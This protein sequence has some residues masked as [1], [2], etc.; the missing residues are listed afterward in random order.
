MAVKGLE[1]NITCSLNATIH[2]MKIVVIFSV[3][4][5]LLLF[6]FLPKFYMGTATLEK[7]L[8]GPQARRPPVSR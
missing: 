4:L 3:V 6:K 5:S 8:S 7:F 1:V 2:S